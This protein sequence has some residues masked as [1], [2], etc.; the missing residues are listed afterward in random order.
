MAWFSG[1]S[2]GD[3]YTV[4]QTYSNGNGSYTA[5]AD[6]T[7]TN[8]RSGSTLV[9]SSQA[10]GVQWGGYESI[11]GGG[12]AALWSNDPQWQ[13]N[14]GS[15]YSS[16]GPAS[17]HV[18]SRG[19]SVTSGPGNPRVGA[20]GSGL[21]LGVSGAGF[22]GSLGVADYEPITPIRVGGE[23]LRLDSSTSDGGTGEQRWG[24]WG[25]GLYGLGVMARD[26]ASVVFKPGAVE[27]DLAKLPAW[28]A[29]TAVDAA[30]MLDERKKAVDH[31]KFLIPQNPRLGGDNTYRYW[32]GGAF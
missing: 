20:R 29:E 14:G 27:A 12:G 8:Q 32:T 5:N 22:A 28:A 24:E 2:T 13:G 6:G 31:S 17:A 3:R 10:A 23:N 9:G 19:G 18:A 25:G 7:F 1:T 30:R 11:A 4:G 26:G 16:E 21:S 15:Q